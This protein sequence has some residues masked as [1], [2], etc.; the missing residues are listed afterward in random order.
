MEGAAVAGDIVSRAN[1]AWDAGCDMLLV[2]NAPD[3]VAALLEGWKPVLD[4]V[5]AARAERLISGGRPLSQDELARDGRYLASIKVIEA[6][7]AS[8]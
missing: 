1:A 3:S 6:M 4:P 7:R 8:A 5:R 2:C